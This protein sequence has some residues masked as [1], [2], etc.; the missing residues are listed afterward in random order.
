[1]TPFDYWPTTR[2]VFGAGTLQQL[3]EVV[4][5]VS[6]AMLDRP[7][8]V[9]L[10]CDWGVIKAGHHDA[11]LRVLKEKSLQVETFRDFG[12]NPTSEM[13]DAGTQVAS[14]FQ[15]DV[16]IGLGGGSSMDCAKGI[17]FVYSC[18][19]SI[20]DYAGVGK[21]TADMLPLIA[22]PT[23][24]GTGSE[25]QSFAL[26]SDART[27]VKMPCGDKRAAARV[28]IL[29]PILTTTQPERVAALA[30]IDALSHAIETHVTKRR[31][32]M[33]ITF[34]K[35][36]F[37]LLGAAFD[38]A[39]KLKPRDELPSDIS[40]VDAHELEMRS[41]MQSGASLAGMAIEMS[42]LGAAHAT[43]N[44]LTARFGIAHGQAVATT[45]PAVI[46]LNAT[47]HDDWY[48]D[49]IRQLPREVLGDT[50]SDSAGD[51]LASLFE[52]WVRAAGLHNT[53]TELGVPSEAISA[54]SEDALQQWTGT[55]NPVGLDSDRVKRIY[56][57]I[58]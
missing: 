30:G 37:G 19:G 25:T 15:P 20:H 57:E 23:T 52:S 39:M 58:L 4:E 33:S 34:S 14:A 53:L 47:A 5:D 31:N 41:Q 44:P 50:I 55:F 3:G 12:E 26:I 7:T 29:D 38:R 27:H 8:R 40:Q 43:A 18:G 2:V 48:A 36:S 51:T 9:L 22:V 56:R 45:L 42:M 32:A 24:T 6:P 54:M 11:A 13:V 17:N 10:V 21:A 28:A 49:L 35:R 1:M 46:R 16:L